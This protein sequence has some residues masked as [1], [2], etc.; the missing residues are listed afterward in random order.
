MRILNPAPL[1]AAAA[2]AAVFAKGASLISKHALERRYLDTSGNYNVTI[3]HTGD[4]HA[5]LDQWRAGT[6]TNCVPGSEC[7]AGY[8]RIKQKINELRQNLRD[9]IFLNAGDE[10]QVC[11][12]PL[13]LLNPL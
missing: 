12:D 2:S 13:F 10:F 6:G 4:V 3:V 7:I 5:H 9:P 8:A 11:V 1:I